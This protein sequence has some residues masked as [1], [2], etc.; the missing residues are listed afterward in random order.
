MRYNVLIEMMNITFYFKS[1]F[2]KSGYQVECINNGLESV[3]L[4][5]F[6]SDILFIELRCRT[7][8]P[9]FQF[10]NLKEYYP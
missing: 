9:S 3:R 8:P 4:I 6:Q 1:L 7:P 5:F 10:I 2:S